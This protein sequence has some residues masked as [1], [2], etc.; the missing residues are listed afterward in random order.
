MIPTPLVRYEDE[1]DD[2]GRHVPLQIGSPQSLEYPYLLL[3]QS[4]FGAFFKL[5]CLILILVLPYLF[6]IKVIVHRLL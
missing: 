1:A 5:A 2:Q 6:R 3:H 4:Q